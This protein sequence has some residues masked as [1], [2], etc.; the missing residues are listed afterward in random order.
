MRLLRFM[1]K[2]ELDSFMAGN[3]LCNDTDWSSGISKTNSKG[4][5]F[6]PV[7]E[8]YDPPERRVS[9]MAGVACLDM[10]VIFETN[11]PLEKTYGMYRDPDEKLP[12]SL[13]DTL[14]TPPKMKRQVEYCTTSYSNQTMIIRK[15]GRPK[16]VSHGWDIDWYWMDE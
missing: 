10:A 11:Q 9:Y 6:F 2:E 7:G 3:I 13:F 14:F 8:Q 1:S 15:M 5:C 16:L 12:E 4:F